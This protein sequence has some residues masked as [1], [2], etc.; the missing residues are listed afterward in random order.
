MRVL[1]VGTGEIAVP[2]LLA[3]D[4]K[5]DVVGVVTQP[6]RPAGRQQKM[7]PSPVKQAAF[8]KHLKIYQPDNINTPASLAQLKYLMPDVVIVCAY[9]QILKKSILTLAERGCLNIHASL[10]PRHRGAA[11]IQA[12]IAQGD[13]KTGITIMQMD[14]GLD[15]GPILSAKAITI[16]KSDTAGTLHDRLAQLAPDLLL[17][18]L[19]KWEKGKI[20][21]Q[22]QDAKLATYAKKLKKEDGHIDWNLKQIEVERHIRAMNPWPCAYAWIPEGE[23]Q[24]MLKIFSCILSKRAKGKPGEILKIDKHGILVACSQGG[25]LLREVQLEGKKKMHASDFVRGYNLP[26]GTIFE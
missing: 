25:L 15:T 26:V 21:P 14:E 5:H 19:D 2:S 13:K 11:C 1:F 6:D 23:D 24:K 17:K 12:A 4:G 7:Q 16:A 8:S 20:K 3:L 10:L 18:T 9:G 22:T